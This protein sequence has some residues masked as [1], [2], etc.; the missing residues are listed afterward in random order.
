[1]DCVEGR[2]RISDNQVFNGWGV[3]VVD[4]RKG[5]KVGGKPRF[6]LNV[7]DIPQPSFEQVMQRPEMKKLLATQLRNQSLS[8]LKERYEREAPKFLTVNYGV[9]SRAL[10]KDEHD[11]PEAKV[12]EKYGRP[13]S[14]QSFFSAI[15][16]MNLRFG[17]PRNQVFSAKVDQPFFVADPKVE[18]LSGVRTSKTEISSEERNDKQ[19][20]EEQQ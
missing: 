18:K 20:Q 6:A 5:I 10:N 2:F 9:E 8:Q 14:S 3:P 11:S 15:R 17:S 4:V 16:E 1:M 7:M 19:A 12:I 13:I